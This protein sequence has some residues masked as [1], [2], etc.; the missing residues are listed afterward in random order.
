M[1]AYPAAQLW[2]PGHTEGSELYESLLGR[3][4][5]L[6][7]VVEEPRRGWMAEIGGFRLEV[8]SPARRFADINDESI[9]LFVTGGSVTTLLTGDI[10]STAQRELGIVDVDIL[11]VPHHGA[12]TTDLDWLAKS[13]A[14]RAIISV[15]P[16][17]FGHPHPDVLAVLEER[18]A[19]VLRTDI[20]GDVVVPLDR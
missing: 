17:D 1:A 14:P 20:D 2:H 11:K 9:V 6:G 10:E 13:A 15:G 3:A 16:N 18:D 12:A 5:E 8:L 4:A 19:E 7:V